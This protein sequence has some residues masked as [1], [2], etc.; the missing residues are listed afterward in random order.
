M[1]CHTA[2]TNIITDDEQ[3]TLPNETVVSPGRTDVSKD[4]VRW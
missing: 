4:T 3:V 2:R 1:H